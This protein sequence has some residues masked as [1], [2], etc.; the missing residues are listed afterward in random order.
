M[1]GCS[2]HQAPHPFP[3]D[4]SQ[5]L[6]TRCRRRVKTQQAPYTVLNTTDFCDPVA[7]YEA[8]GNSLTHLSSSSVLCKTPTALSRHSADL[9]L[10]FVG[11]GACVMGTS[12]IISSH[13]KRRFKMSKSHKMYSV[14]LLYCKK[15]DKHKYVKYN[16]IAASVISCHHDDH[17]TKEYHDKK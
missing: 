14:K 15:Y 11:T 10:V 12:L 3:S 5:R 16:W 8:E 17:Q 9:R 1:Y 6:V 13:M 4:T 2:C 7:V